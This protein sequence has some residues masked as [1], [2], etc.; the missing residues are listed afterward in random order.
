MLTVHQ[1]W[2]PLKVCAVGRSYPPEFYSRIK[3]PKVRNVLE[4]IAIETEEDYQKLINLLKKFNVTVLRTDVS[5]DPEDYI[6]NGVLN[7]PP[8]MVPRDF[9][10]MIGNTFY[11]P[12]ASYGTNLTWMEDESL[13]K[14]IE[15]FLE[16]NNKVSP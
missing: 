6:T 5:E 7:V 8:P 1:H 12:G 4:K 16:P 11:M 10:A 3:N 13:A 9:T 14:K 15:D 2:D